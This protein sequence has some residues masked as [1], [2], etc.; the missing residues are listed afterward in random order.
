MNKKR[1]LNIGCGKE[2]YGTDFVDLYPQRKEVKE[3]NL[4][5]EKLPYKNNTFEEVYSAFLFE[6][7]KDPHKVLLEM[8]RVLKK[9]GKIILI[10]DNAGF[11]GFHT[12]DTLWWKVHNG[13]YNKLSGRG[14]GDLHFGLFTLS[15][16]ITHLKEAGFRNIKVKLFKHKRHKFSFKTSFI[17]NLLKETKFEVMAYPNIYAEAVK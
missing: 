5:Y 16:I 12:K 10:T 8:K 4:D 13:G 6:H 15:H 9:G 11:L 1:I 2:T 7:L 17:C 14:E 3:V